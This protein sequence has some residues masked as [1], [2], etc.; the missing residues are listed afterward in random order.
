MLIHVNSYRPRPTTGSQLNHTHSR[1]VLKRL[2]IHTGRA[3]LR[4]HLHTI[5]QVSF[6]A[7]QLHNNT[8]H[9]QINSQVTSRQPHMQVTVLQEEVSPHRPRFT[10]NNMFTHG[11][12]R[13]Q[14]ATQH[15]H[16]VKVIL[17]VIL[18]TVILRLRLTIIKDHVRVQRSSNSRHRHRRSRNNHHDGHSN[19][20]LR[21]PNVLFHGQNKLIRYK[22]L[23]MRILQ[24][25]QRALSNNLRNATVRNLLRTLRIT[26]RLR[27]KV[28]AVL[29]HATRNLARRPFRFNQ[30]IK[31]I[32]LKRQVIRGSK[33]RPFNP[34]LPL[35]VTRRV[36]MRVLMQQLTSRRNRR[37]NTGQVSVKQFVTTATLNGRLQHNPH[38]NRT[39]AQAPVSN[40]NS[41]R[42]NRRK[43]VIHI[44]RGVTKLSI[45]VSSTFTVHN[46]R[47]THRVSTSNRRLI[48]NR[49]TVLRR[50]LMV[51]TQDMFRRNMTTPI[52]NRTILVS[53][54][55]MKIYKSLPR[56]VH[57][58]ARTSHNA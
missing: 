18:N 9:I 1:K 25:V 13:T 54:G 35:K 55:G 21:P 46:R 37:H 31:A 45:S 56:R 53:K 39:S 16:Q 34:R 36:N 14:R 20:Q 2:P 28:M 26:H 5:N 48:N 47:H 49:A 11:V 38:S 30:R 41:T 24:V 50:H 19:R 44:S 15:S 10:I 51:T 33:L 42:V 27:H 58:K 7:H 6:S 17:N 23:H 8:L 57:F 22:D 43:R 12:L 52:S 40:P 4:T 32:R 29:K 3:R